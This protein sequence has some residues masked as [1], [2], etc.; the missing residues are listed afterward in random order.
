M[1]S[2]L[3]RGGSEECICKL[4]L[5]MEKEYHTV[6]FNRLFF[7]GFI[8]MEDLVEIVANIMGISSTF[9]ECSSEV[10]MGSSGGSDDDSGIQSGIEE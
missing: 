2:F 5:M 1:T 3:I 7:S 6:I 10:V 8:L 9:F 4:F